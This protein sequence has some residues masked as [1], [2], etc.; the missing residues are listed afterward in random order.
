M[1]NNVK[2]TWDSRIENFVFEMVNFSAY[3]LAL[4]VKPFEKDMKKSVMNKF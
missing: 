3:E 2:N 1:V 4:D